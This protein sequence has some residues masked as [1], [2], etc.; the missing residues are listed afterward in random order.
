MLAGSPDRD[1]THREWAPRWWQLASWVPAV[2]FFAG[3]LSVANG[4]HALWPHEAFYWLAALGVLTPLVAAVA[5]SPGVWRVIVALSVPLIA[6]AT[7]AT[8]WTVAQ[9]ADDGC[10]S[11]SVTIPDDMPARWIG[12]DLARG[13]VTCDWH[14]DSGTRHIVTRSPV[15]DVL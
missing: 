10:F 4:S 12:I 13:E 3:C 8:T 6:L 9:R 2:V 14:D 5:R 7:V 11:T 1:P 15:T